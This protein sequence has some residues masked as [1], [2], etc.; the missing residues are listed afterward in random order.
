MEGWRDG[1]I[2]GGAEAGKVLRADGKGKTAGQTNKSEGRSDV[3]GGV[4]VGGGVN[5]VGQ[6]REET[7]L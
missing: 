3:M 5:R 7:T 1:K 2:G 4:A 6:R